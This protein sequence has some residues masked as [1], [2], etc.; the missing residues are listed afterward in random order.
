MVTTR[1]TGVGKPADTSSLQDSQFDTNNAEEE[2]IPPKKGP[3]DRLQSSRWYPAQIFALGSSVVLLAALSSHLSLPSPVVPEV[4]QSIFSEGRVRQLVSSISF[5]S[6]SFN[7]QTGSHINEVV[8]PQRLLDFLHHDILQNDALAIIANFTYSLFVDPTDAFTPPHSCLCDLP[9]LAEAVAAIRPLPAFRKLADF[10]I[11]EVL[12]TGVQKSEGVE[13]CRQSAAVAAC[14]LQTNRT[15]SLEAGDVYGVH[16]VHRHVLRKQTS[17]VGEVVPQDLKAMF[18]RLIYFDTSYYSKFEGFFFLDRTGG[19][20]MAYSGIGNV[21]ARASP[22]FLPHSLPAT[23]D[24]LP[25]LMLASH[26]DGFPQ[27]PA[28]ADALSCV[29]IALETLRNLLYGSN[30][31]FPIIVNLNGSEETSLHGGHA[32]SSGHPW[33]RQVAA[34]MNLESSG[35]GGREHLFQT[36][37]RGGRLLE[38]YQRA[39]PRPHGTSV[40]QDLFQAGLIPGDT[41]F[42]IFRDFL[43]AQ[44]MDFA[45][46]GIGYNYHTVRDQLEMM[47]PG[48]I[49]RYGETIHAVAQAASRD[50]LERYQQSWS[51]VKDSLK[52]ISATFYSSSDSYYYFD[53]LGYWFVLLPVSWLRYLVLSLGVLWFCVRR[54]DRSLLQI[55]P[56]LF[57]LVAS[58]AVSATQILAA[59]L[60]CSLTAGLLS[61]CG[62]A[63]RW[64]SHMWLAG[65]LYAGVAL[66]VSYFVQFYLFGL[67]LSRLPTGTPTDYAEEA[68]VFHGGVLTWS[69]LLVLCWTFGLAVT[70][71][72]LLWLAG[73]ILGRL[74]GQI[75]LIQTRSRKSERSFHKMVLATSET[76]GLLLPRISTM[77][78]LLELADALI[79]AMGNIY[80]AFALLAFNDRHDA[81]THVH[82][83]QGEQIQRGFPASVLLGC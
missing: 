69:V 53:I 9:S 64:F 81:S 62:L 55:S 49:Q 2:A 29:G 34:V 72:S 11:Q 68:L 21:A 50:M 77:G 46:A 51:A 60:A 63:L 41:D 32:F 10:D 35:S 33:A 7:Q 37:R 24:L 31:W 71:V 14:E 74:T 40:S 65:L 27:S 26:Y 75:V 20:G 3:K 83:H 39:A 78:M 44:G 76:A 4:D 57:F 42:R 73:A 61:A 30:L 25:A 1:R 43:G 28:A 23:T 59:C 13:L 5:S 56:S 67:L 15:T 16:Q 82:V 48:T 52:P 38:M 45:I 22:A 79:P 66:V 19:F 8:V 47:P 58:V 36:T 18:D 17:S 80:S 70:Y 6:P 12:Q 54:L